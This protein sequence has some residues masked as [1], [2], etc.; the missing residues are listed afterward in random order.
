[1][2]FSQQLVTFCAVEGWKIQLTVT[3]VS[4]LAMHLAVSELMHDKF[5]HQSQSADR[6][7]ADKDFCCI[8]LIHECKLL[9]IA[10]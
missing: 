5:I 9:H 2:P 4:R 10:Y 7:V 1:V 6:E 8:T 3:N